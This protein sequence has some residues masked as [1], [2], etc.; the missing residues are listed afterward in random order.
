MLN[1]CS[2]FERIA[3]VVLDK[4]D[5]DS[6]IRRKRKQQDVSSDRSHQRSQSTVT[7]ASTPAGTQNTAAPG[8]IP[9]V[10]T[11]PDIMAGIPDGINVRGSRHTSC[12]SANDIQRSAYANSPGQI[13]LSP[14]PSLL[15]QSFSPRPPSSALPSSYPTSGPGID[16]F[17]PISTPGTTSDPLDLGGS[18]QHPFVPQDLWQMPMTLEWDWAD[19]TGYGPGMDGGINNPSIGANGIENGDMLGDES[20]PNAND[21]TTP[22]ASQ[23]G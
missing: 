14:G 22:T 23:S 4:V 5:K 11:P 17:S 15:Q 18:F 8:N 7:A 20:T 16:A 13:G 12:C 1:V 9:N 19:M 10:Y 2:E 6:S 3:K 21:G